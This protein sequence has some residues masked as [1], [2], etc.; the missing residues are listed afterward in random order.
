MSSS[1]DASNEK[2]GTVETNHPPDAVG[3]EQFVILSF[4]EDERSLDVAVG[5]SGGSRGS[6]VSR[7]R[8]CEVS[9][10]S[11]RWT[12]EEMKDADSRPRV[13]ENSD[14]SV[15]LSV[16]GVVSVRRR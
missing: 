12:L 15:V 5:L 14:D 10:D 1:L 3:I 9:L 8:R 4:A 7:E 2:R 6:S 13:N 11:E 16:S